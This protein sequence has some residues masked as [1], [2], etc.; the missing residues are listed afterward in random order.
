M[1]FRTSVIVLALLAAGCGGMSSEEKAARDTRAIAHVEAAQEM[2]PPV[3][4]LTPEPMTPGV[5][6]VFQL[7]D[8]GCEFRPDPSEGAEPVLVADGTRAVLLL[9]TE[10]AIFAADSGS[11]RLPAGVYS[12]YVGRTHS[13]Q[14]AFDPDVLTVR[15]RFERIVYQAAGSLTCHG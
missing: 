15:D 2:R 14:L 7:V 1:T 10:P 5:R 4:A 11:L 12:H 13:A 8:A 9:A 3:Q 6:K